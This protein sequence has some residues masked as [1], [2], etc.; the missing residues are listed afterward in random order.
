MSAKRLLGGSTP[1]AASNLSGERMEEIP[2]LFPYISGSKEYFIIDSGLR[3]VTI[4]TQQ[5]VSV[6][7]YTVWVYNPISESLQ[8]VEA[9][10]SVEPLQK[11]YGVKT[12]RSRFNSGQSAA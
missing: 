11:K 1:P 10:D 4:S 6:P 2:E 3:M 7:R 5:S 12:V 8:I 9:G